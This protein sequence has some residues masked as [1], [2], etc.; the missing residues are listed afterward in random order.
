MQKINQILKHEN[1]INI[2]ILLIATAFICLPL[3]SEHLNIGYDDGIQHIARLMGTYQ[4][5]MEKQD[6]PVIMSNFCNEF[7]YSWNIFYSPL[8]AY[9]PLIFKIFGASFSGCIK[10]F[11]FLTCFLSGISMYYFTKDVT[12]NKKMALIAGIFYIFA[13]YRLTDMY[14]RNALAE[15]TSFVFVPMI[16]QRTL[17]YFERKEK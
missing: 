7:G 8:T 6:F 10:I 13:P 11:M 4:S 2:L 1:L 15:F 12:K 3:L 17:W 9:V 14:A 16:F 5:I